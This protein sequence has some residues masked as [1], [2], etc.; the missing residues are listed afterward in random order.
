MVSQDVKFE[1]NLVSRK[2][3]ELPPVEENEE[4]VAPKREQSSQTSSSGSHPSG[5]EELAPFSSVKRPRW[6][7]QTLGDARKHV[8]TPGYRLWRVCL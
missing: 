4:Q 1:E 8:E 2:S 7:E 5:E 6:F 3:H